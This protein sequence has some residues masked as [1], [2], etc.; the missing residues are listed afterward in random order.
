MKRLTAN[1][2]LKLASLVFAAIVWFL[3]TNINDPISSVRYANIPVVLKNTETITSKGQVYTVL[4]GSDTI[5]SVTVYAPRSVIDALSQNNIVATADVQELSSLNT[6]GIDVTTNKYSDKIDNIVTS[7]DIVKLNVERN[8]S[9]SLEV[10]CTTSGTLSEGYII[11][12]K[13]MDQNMIL[14]SGA[15]SIVQSVKEARVDVDVTGWTSYIGAEPDIILYDEAGNEVDSSQLKMNIKSV[16]VNVTILATKTVP[17]RYKISGT[18]ATGYDLTGDIDSRPSEVTIAGRSNIL[19]TIKEIVVDADELDVS[20]LSS[21]LTYTVDLND[22]LPS[23]ASFASDFKGKATVIV[24]IGPVNEH[25]LDIDI[26]NVSIADSV[27][28]YEVTIDET[29]NDTLSLTVEGLDNKIS[30]LNANALKG[31]VNI[32]KMMED[33][34]ITELSEGTYS[35]EVDWALPKGVTF[36]TPVNVHIKVKKVD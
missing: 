21:N 29:E 31:T 19:K 32:K 35:A 24:H 23:G 4:D 11:G 3:V 10:T 13:T 28:G 2:G 27:E 17:I 22:Y 25:T 34:N 14:I 20:G 16:R 36:K 1:W 26:S 15:E 7:S 12:D 30:T 5:S 6:V 18:P 33:N 8:V 9:K